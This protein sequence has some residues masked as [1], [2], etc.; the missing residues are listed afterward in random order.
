M[1]KITK[2]TLNKKLTI[3]FVVALIGVAIIIAGMF[4]PHM[5]AVGDLAEYIE[6]Y[7]DGVGIKEFEMTNSDLKNVPM[8]FMGR[9]AASAYSEEEG[10]LFNVI[11]IVFAFF[12]A[13]TALFIILK[14][15]IA[16]MIFEV[17]TCGVFAFLNFATKED[18][19]GA[20][21]YAS[22]IGYYAIIAAFVIV[23]V[24]AIWMLVN[25]IAAKKEMKAIPAPATEV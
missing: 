3:P 23:F 1:D 2:Q 24:G 6:E 25:K 9:I 18:F 5:T 13:L 15:P 19:F 20:D 16:V 10:I 21:K 11:V 22:G 12:L 8:I 17:I 14:K 7:P 4:L